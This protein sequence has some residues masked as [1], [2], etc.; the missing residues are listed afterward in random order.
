MFPGKPKIKAPL[1]SYYVLKHSMI[2][3]WVKLRERKW[4]CEPQGMKP[5]GGCTLLAKCRQA[6]PGAWLI[7]G[8]RLAESMAI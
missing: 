7:L 2:Q 8:P 5:S 3:R 6:L 1:I 4:P